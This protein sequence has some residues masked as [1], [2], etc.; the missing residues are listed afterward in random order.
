MAILLDGKYRENLQPYGVYDYVEKYSHTPG[1]AK[2]GLYCYNFCLDTN[3]I[4]MSAIWRYE[5]V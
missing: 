3:P 1:N 5:H 2:D 4:Y